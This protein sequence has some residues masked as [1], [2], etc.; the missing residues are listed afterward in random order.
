[1]YMVLKMSHEHEYHV[2]TNFTI[3]FHAFAVH[4]GYMRKIPKKK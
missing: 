3:Q 4:I 2:F 1:M